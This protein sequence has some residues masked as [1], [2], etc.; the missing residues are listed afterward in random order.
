M[1]VEAAYDQILASQLTARLS[2]KVANTDVLFADVPT[3]KR[4]SSGSGGGGGLRGGSN[5][6]SAGGSAGGFL[7]QLPALN[8]AVTVASP[9]SEMAITSATVFGA[10]AAWT[11]AQGLLD[12]SPSSPAGEVPGIQLALGVAAA[13]YLLR[14]SVR[15]CVCVGGEEGG[16]LCVCT[17]SPAHPPD[18]LY[19]PPPPSHPMQDK[20]KT[21][22][23]KAAGLAFGGLVLGTLLGS[24]VESWLR[25]DLVPLGVSG[26]ACLFF[27]FSLGG[28]G[29]GAA[30]D[31]RGRDCIVS[32]FHTNAH[33][34]TPCRSPLCA[35]L[36]C[37]ACSRP[38]FWWANSHWLA[39]GRPASSW[40]EHRGLWSR[41]LSSWQRLKGALEG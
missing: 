7:Q 22:L 35:L 29:W 8:S 5:G 23:G 9:S 13:V 24:G 15:V 34:K 16:V 19:P 21:G 25:V 3:P 32:P 2:G 26:C 36:V 20:K 12:P 40:G 33:T 39:S 37:R 6:G 30:E 17:L 41:P 11:L 10:L 31:R 38:A 28:W 14:V 4:R 27:L 1:Q 18:P